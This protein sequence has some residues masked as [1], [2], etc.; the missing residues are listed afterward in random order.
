[1]ITSNKQ[2]K[3]RCMRAWDYLQKTSGL[4]LNAD[5]IKKVHKIMMEN[6]K[7]VLAGEFRKSPVFLRYRIFPPA[8]TIEKLVDDTLYRYYHPNGIN[9]IL[10]TANLFVDL[11]N[12][13]PFEDGNGRL[14][15]MILSHVFMRGGCSLFSVLLRS[16]NKRGRWHYIQAVNRY[17]ENPSLLYTMIKSSFLDNFEQNSKMLARC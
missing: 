17:H 5:F 16:F 11:I 14:C 10:A 9:P 1:M 7:G 2:M 6:E 13:H 8:D 3:E 15:R 4:L 12:I